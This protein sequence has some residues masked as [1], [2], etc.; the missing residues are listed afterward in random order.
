MVKQKCSVFKTVIVII[1]GVPSFLIFTVFCVTSGNMKTHLRVHT[2][3]KPFPCREENCGK[4][5]R[6]A[7]SLRRH[8]LSHKG[9][10]L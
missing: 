10:S 1:L 4:L 6:S 3:E 2:G 7:E 5:F 9:K 8:V